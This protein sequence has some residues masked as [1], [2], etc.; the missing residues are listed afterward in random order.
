M[1]GRLN[2]DG[3]RGVVAGP[4]GPP[5]DLMKLAGVEQPGARAV[6]LRQG[7]EDHGPDRHVDTDAEGV[8]AADDL[9][10]AGLGQL[11]HQPPVL[12]QHPGVVNADPMPDQSRQR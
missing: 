4:P 9:E 1:I 2:D 8:G 3:A 5:G 12:G 10:Q 11:F 7:R 6:V